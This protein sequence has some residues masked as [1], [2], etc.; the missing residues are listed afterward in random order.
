MHEHGAGTHSDQLGGLGCRW[1]WEDER[2][3]LGWGALPGKCKCR[4]GLEWFTRRKNGGARPGGSKQK[5]LNR[6]SFMVDCQE[7]RY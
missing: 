2:C 1:H 6:F 5:L 7:Y 3:C 4:R